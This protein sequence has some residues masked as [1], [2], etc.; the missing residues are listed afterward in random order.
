MAGSMSTQADA[1]R[2]VRPDLL[3]LEFWA[4]PEAERM[5]VFAELRR[6]DGLTYVPFQYRMPVRVRTDGV[7]ALTR[8]ADV[9]E[10]SRNPAL[11]SS[12]PTSN[13]LIDMP[14]WLDPYFTSMISMD[15][16]RHARIRKVVSRAFSPKLLAKLEDDLARRAARIVDDVLRDGPG[17][18]VAQVAQRLPTQVICDMMGIP[19]DHQAAVLRHTNTILGFNDPE[20]TGIPREALLSGR[21]LRTDHVLRGTVRLLRAG[22]ALTR[23]VRRLGKDR[24]R[25]PREDLI[26][27]LVTNNVD[28]DR[29]TPR[30]V[31]TFFILLVVA[32]SETTR[33]A[34]AHAIR[35]F[36]EHPD[37]RAL[38]TAD[39]DARIGGAIEELIRY[40]TPVIQFRRTVTRDCELGGTSLHAGDKV[41]LFYTSANRDET[42]FDDP[43]RFDIT[44]SP[45]PHV[46]FGG[47]GPHYCLGANLARRELTVMLRELFTRMPDVHMSAPPEMLLSNFLHGI[48][49]LPFDL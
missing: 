17:D 33:N 6:C 19:E 26:S 34:L 29:L 41:L 24:I 45:N 23:L 48:K 9:V 35:L 43:D 47:P 22:D 44:R 37:Q 27:A 13:S 14:A 2:P 18:F 3:G 46:G 16:P 49:R 5:A 32:G 39:F 38:L 25:E 12:E 28:G 15:D 36:T 20:Y 31:G 1:E 7:Y 10:A 40:T 4:R 42:V 30:E 11:F 21:P 8:H